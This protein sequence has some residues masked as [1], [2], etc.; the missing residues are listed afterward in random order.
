MI[1]YLVFYLWQD[2]YEESQARVRALE[3]HLAALQVADDDEEEEEGAEEDAEEGADEDRAE[4]DDE[5]GD[6][7][8]WQS[9]P[10]PIDRIRIWNIALLFLLCPSLLLV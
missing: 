5:D 9:T 10:F 6:G 3:R 4:G 8:E 1:S 2:L 7:E